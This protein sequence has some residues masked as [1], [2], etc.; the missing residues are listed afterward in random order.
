M[1]TDS[2]LPPFS[3]EEWEYA[4]EEKEQTDIAM[5]EA[6]KGGSRPGSK[7]TPSSGS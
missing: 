1:A 6:V 3:L 2:D 7:T 4:S 5:S